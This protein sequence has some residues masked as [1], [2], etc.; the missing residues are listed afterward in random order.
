[1]RTLPPTSPESV[2]QPPNSSPAPEPPRAAAKKSLAS[3]LHPWLFTVGDAFLINLAFVLAWFIRYQLEFGREV[4]EQDYLPLG[5]YTTIQLVLTGLMLTSFWLQGLYRRR[6]RLGWA[7]EVAVFAT[8]SLVSVAALIVGVFYVRPFGY[9]RLIFIYAL[10]LCV[11][12][13]TISRAVVALVRD[14]QR[15]HGIGLRRV[16][17]VGDSRVG[18]TIVQN[19]VAQ[20]ELGYQIVGFVND[21]PQ[22]KIGRIPYLGAVAQTPDLIR[23]HQVEE[24]IIALPSASHQQVTQLVM[25]CDRNNVAFRIVPDFFELSL[26]QLDVEDINGIPLI[27]LREARLPTHQFLLKRIIDVIVSPILLV[28]TSPLVA[29]IIIS[30][31]LNSAGPVFVKQQRIGRLGKPFTFYKFRSMV[32]DAQDQLTSLLVQN[33]ADGPIFKMKDDP[34]VTYVGRIIRRFSMDELPQLYNVLRGEMSLVGPRP[35]FPHEVEQYR[36]WHLRR[37]SVAP[38]MTGLWQVS[39]RSDLPFDEMALLDLWY[40][41][42]WSLSLDLK[43]LL[44]TIPAV[45]FGYGAY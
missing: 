22:D 20:P 13:L 43:I 21:Q 11:V 23:Q 25:A 34:R 18:P 7:D 33:Q 36:D 9:S 26:N 12:L 15:R 35:A 1:M 14:Y 24:I 45:L 42:N 5:S 44:R 40:V 16:L 10:V 19:I 3:A 4:A 17:V 6:R 31:K 28:L 37:L 27:G 32:A 39:G 8:G 30:I 29:L 41:E 38:G 2:G